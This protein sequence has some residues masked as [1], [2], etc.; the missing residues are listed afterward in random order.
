MHSW[1]VDPVQTNSPLSVH[2]F[3]DTYD[4]MLH[5]SFN[6]LDRPMS[7]VP[8]TAQIARSYICLIHQ[9][10]GATQAIWHW[11]LS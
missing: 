10:N 4:L 5:N 11:A 7:G 1:G 6:Q 3:M 9:Q 2:H 8:H